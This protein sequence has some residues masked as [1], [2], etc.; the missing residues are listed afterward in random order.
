MKRKTYIDNDFK[1]SNLPMNRNDVFKDVVSLHYRTL[2]LLGVILLLFSIP[3]QLSAYIYDVTKASIYY[4]YQDEL[5]TFITAQNTLVSMS[6]MFHTINIL[7]I[8]LLGVGLAGVIRVIKQLSWYEPI[9]TVADFLTGVKENGVQFILLALIVGILVY[10]TNLISS[11]SVFTSDDTLYTYL[12]M[13][14]KT[15]FTLIFA[16]IGLYMIVIIPIYSNRFNS[17]VRLGIY[18]FFVNIIKTYK[19]TVL[20]ALPFLLL[21]IPNFYVTII[22]RILLSITLPFLLLKWFLL[23][24]DLL[25]MHWNQKYYPNLVHRGIL[26]K[27]YLK[28]NI[29]EKN[30]L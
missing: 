5:I 28:E 27:T 12:G 15:L 17:Q 20:F 10:I 30:I 3:M 6:N 21:L 7:F 26:G 22:A 14:P 4:E 29:N 25:D 16:P 18:L 2:L 11:L 19:T 8:V 13:I 9:S 1:A 23:V 24:S